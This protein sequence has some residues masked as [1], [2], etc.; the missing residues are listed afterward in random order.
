MRFWL[1]AF[2]VMFAAVELFEWVAQLGSWQPTGV[3]LLLGGMGLA[4]LSN[5]A[6]WGKATDV[7]AL[8]TDSEE[9]AIEKPSHGK[10][11]S[12]DSAVVVSAEQSRKAESIADQSTQD[13]IS[14]KVRPLKR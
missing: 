7:E 13:S 11:A 5:A 14:F 2:V 8:K 12:T 1:A 10:I 9:P 4:V 6:H 3:W